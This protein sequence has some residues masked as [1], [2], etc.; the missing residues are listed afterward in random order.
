[1]AKF[2]VQSGKFQG[3]VDS[4]NAETAAQWA[5]HQAMR[6]IM[7]LEEDRKITLEPTPSNGLE[8]KSETKLHWDHENPSE[9][10]AP[11]KPTLN[12]ESIADLKSH[13]VWENDDLD[14]QDECSQD[15]CSWV[16]RQLAT[17]IS[18][19]GDWEQESFSHQSNLSQK[20]SR[21]DRLSESPCTLLVFEEEVEEIC[22]LESSETDIIA[23]AENISVSER[24]FD[25][26]DQVV[27]D[28]FTA[29]QQWNQLFQA[30]ETLD[31]T[32][33]SHRT[34]G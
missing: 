31:R 15:E 8:T 2:Y 9:V 20:F 17:Q 26:D 27:V 29:F 14:G 34:N 4:H 7:P 18:K 12:L 13:I 10:T 6:Q 19:Y 28:T 16:D 21:F 25:A 22:K 24:G 23:L 33:E 30:I 11:P 3:I 1:M 32:F 5:V